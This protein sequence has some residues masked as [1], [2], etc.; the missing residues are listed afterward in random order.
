MRLFLASNLCRILPFTTVVLTMLLAFALSARFPLTA[1]FVP[2]LV[3]HYWSVPQPLY[4]PPW[5]VFALGIFE[6]LL[7]A[8][9]LGLH[10]CLWV[11]FYAC[12]RST[13]FAVQQSRIATLT[14]H[15]A[16]LSFVVP[17][18]LA[19]LLLVQGRGLSG[20]WEVLWGWGSAPLVYPLVAIV[21]QRMERDLLDQ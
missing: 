9:P 3:I 1:A 2:L 15:Y 13:S 14:L 6:D 4:M 8:T 20:S 5:L 17:V 21:L 12:A 10:A 16:L 11:A 19:V 7:L 18:V